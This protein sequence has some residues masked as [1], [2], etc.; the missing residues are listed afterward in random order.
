MTSP[1]ALALPLDVAPGGPSIRTDT[2]QDGYDVVRLRSQDALE[3]TFA[4]QVGMT[5]CSLRHGGVE[6]IGERYGLAAYA[7]CGITMGM[8]LMHPWAPLPVS[9]LLHTDRWACRSTGCSPA[10]MH[11]SCRTVAP[12]ASPH[13]SPRRCP[14]TVIP[15]GLS[16][17]RS[18]IGFTCAPR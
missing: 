8:S 2:T 12:R 16:C 6:L 7:S 10:A 13:G 4:A 11:G 18:R 9:P 3:A 14:S 1:A 5:C 17:S 15:D